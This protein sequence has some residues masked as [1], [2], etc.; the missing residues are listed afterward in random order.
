MNPIVTYW[1][2][3]A[4]ACGC[5]DCPKAEKAK[6]D[7]PAAAAVAT[8]PAVELV[9]APFIIVEQ[10]RCGLNLFNRQPRTQVFIAR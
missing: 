8:V 6:A 10:P 7:K 9:P 1:T 4:A 2:F 3:A 5:P